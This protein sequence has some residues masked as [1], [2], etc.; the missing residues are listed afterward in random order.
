MDLKKPLS[1]DDQ[2]KMLKAHGVVL[3]SSKEAEY[4]SI[5]SE[6]NYYRLSGYALQFRLGANDSNYVK[7]TTFEQIYDI[8]KFDYDARQMIRKYIEI[9]E[10]YFRTQ[11]AYNFALAK[12]QQAPHDQHY[13]RNNYFN[14]RGFDEVINSFQKEKNYYKDSLIVKH[15]IQKYSS[16]MPLWV[17][18]ELMSFSNISKLYNTMY[19]SEKDAIAIAAGTGRTMLE[20]NLHCLSVL[21]NKCAHA[22]RLYNTEF[23]PPATLPTTF[24]KKYPV[25]KNNSLFAYLLVLLR[26]LP[27]GKYKNEFAQDINE[28]IDKYAGKIDLKLIGF[29]G[30]YSDILNEQIKNSSST[31]K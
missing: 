7:G 24:L 27:N 17:I 12:C 19:Y 26:R 10:V 1:Y 28:L 16:K 6:V 9:T 2:L 18:V 20:N 14:Q 11:I 29:P 23:N 8:Y 21:R 15:H 31:T 30:N 4:R 5:L 3:D 22:A 25:V 13:D